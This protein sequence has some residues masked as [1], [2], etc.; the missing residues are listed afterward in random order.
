MTKDNSSFFW[1]AGYIY[2]NNITSPIG[3]VYILTIFLP[4]SLSNLPHGIAN[5][6]TFLRL[7]IFAWTAL[8]D[9]MQRLQMVFFPSSLKKCWKNLPP[10]PVFCPS[11]FSSSICLGHS[12]SLTHKLA[13]F[14]FSTILSQAVLVRLT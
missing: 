14:N 5:F 11:S 9:D 2:Q 10:F 12:L 4:E 3:Y 8:T 1:D 6:C 7:P 13:D